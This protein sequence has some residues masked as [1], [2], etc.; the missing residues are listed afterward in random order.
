MKL[1]KNG[2]DYFLSNFDSLPNK[3]PLG[4]YTLLFN[5][6]TRTYYLHKINN[7][8]LPPIIYGNVLEFADRV[9]TKYNNSDRNLGVLLIGTRGAGKNITANAIAKRANLPVILIPE[10]YDD[11]SFI[12]FITDGSLGN[13]VIFID[14]FEKL[15]DDSNDSGNSDKLLS[16]L[17]GPYN[18][19]HLFI[20]AS[21]KFNIINPMMKNRPSRIH[22]LKEF[23]GLDDKTIRDICEDNLKNKDYI[24]EVLD[25]ASKMSAPTY[26]IILS[27]CADC[28]LYN[29]SPKEVIKYLNIVLEEKTYD[30]FRQVETKV[31]FEGRVKLLE[32]GLWSDYVWISSN[33]HEDDDGD[34]SE[35]RFDPNVETPTKTTSDSYTYEIPDEGVTVILKRSNPKQ[36][37]YVF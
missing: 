16:L 13:C 7:L 26:D 25:L 5:S 29:Q 10:G 9:Y 17:D 4:T 28:N 6:E 22:F 30:I 36:I 32:N 24:D 8:Q 27:I 2:Q 20:F 12:S 21:N 34:P 33:I 37:N 3:L 14:E 11:P 19:H 15:Y 35:F 31:S 1:I 23:T 18:T